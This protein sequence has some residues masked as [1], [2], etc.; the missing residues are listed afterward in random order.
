MSS[1]V[2]IFC[3]EVLSRLW[4]NGVND[5]E[6]RA[7]QSKMIRQIQSSKN[8]QKGEE[9]ILVHMQSE[10]G[11]ALNGS[12]AVLVGQDR[13]GP[14]VQ[15]RLHLRLTSAEA[16]STPLRVKP[17]NVVNPRFWSSAPS[18]SRLSPTAIQSLVKVAVESFDHR[19]IE[20]ILSGND[21]LPREDIQARV[22]FL[23]TWQPGQTFP[24]VS[25]TT[26]EKVVGMA[27]YARMDARQQMMVDFMSDA[28]ELGCYGDGCVH[29]ERLAQGLIAIGGETCNICLEEL[30]AGEEMLLLPCGHGFHPA[31]G[32]AS[33]AH[34]RRCPTCRSPVVSEDEADSLENS[35]NLPVQV[36]IRER[37]GEFCISG[38]CER[39]QLANVEGLQF[40]QADEKTARAAP[41]SVRLCSSGAGED[42]M[43]F[44]TSVPSCTPC[45]TPSSSAAQASGTAASAAPAAAAGAAAAALDVTDGATSAPKPAAE[46]P[47]PADEP[48]SSAP[49]ASA[50]ADAAGAPIRTE[51]DWMARCGIEGE[52][53]E[54]LS[55][56]EVKAVVLASMRDD[57]NGLS[58][59]LAAL[60]N[61]VTVRKL[62]KLA[63]MGLFGS[64]GGD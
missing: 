9:Y 44:A 24:C 62:A 27:A 51:A 14:S 48:G 55:D 60:P 17:C 63:Q 12:R 15:W 10:R 1:D 37:F 46:E 31:C 43:R 11:R 33:L 47:A 42:L 53:A 25:C 36:R 35:F 2:G 45:G 58:R 26:T 22:N 54:L 3:F 23:R 49:D 59:L 13:P 41:G 16:G 61:S 64:G 4:P 6:L 19:L 52:A 5:D 40:R 56:P 38:Y 50:G 39:C 21:E 34:Q 30:A 18:R 32:S 7:W 29:P 8:S 57:D 28:R 20:H